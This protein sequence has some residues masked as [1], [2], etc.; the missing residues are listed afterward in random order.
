MH[1]QGTIRNLTSQLPHQTPK[2]LRL[3]IQI[4]IPKRHP[5]PHSYTAHESTIIPYNPVPKHHPS[6]HHRHPP[7]DDAVLANADREVLI[8][9]THLTGFLVQGELRQQPTF[10]NGLG[11]ITDLT[12][13]CISNMT[14]SLFLEKWE[15]EK[16]TV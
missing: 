6:P 14:F 5:G 7:P 16:L 9:S 2:T 10:M 4:P 12:N 8:Q 11:H 1:Q 13:H 3:L 15:R